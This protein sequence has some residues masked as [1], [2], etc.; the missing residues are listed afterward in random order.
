MVQL[1]ITP[2]EWGGTRSEERVGFGESPR[3]QIELFS[4]KGKPLALAMTSRTWKTHNAG[5]S[6][7]ETHLGS[8]SESSDIVKNNN[9]GRKERPRDN[10]RA[11]SGTHS[12]GFGHWP[13][14]G[15][16]G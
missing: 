13:R 6:V 3:I 2:E 12:R 1:H 5:A 14:V 10:L 9:E 7:L 8:H 4:V 15:I 11:A 16:P